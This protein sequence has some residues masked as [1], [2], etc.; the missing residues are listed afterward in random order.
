MVRIWISL[1]VIRSPK[2]PPII[3]RIVDLGTS[4]STKV[5]VT[6]GDHHHALPRVGVEDH[7]V[8]IEVGK[9]GSRIPMGAISMDLLVLLLLLLFGGRLPTGL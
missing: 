4:T 3:A 6:G 9:S 8:P 2:A 5:L 7:A 1:E